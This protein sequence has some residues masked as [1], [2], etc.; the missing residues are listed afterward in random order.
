M[1]G[2][3]VSVPLSKVSKQSTTKLKFGD[4]GFLELDDFILPR[5][6][7]YSDFFKS[8]HDIPT[9]SVSSTRI[10]DMHFMEYGV[11]KENKIKSPKQKEKQHME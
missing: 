7:D 1:L 2:K 6:H 9:G 10:L 5:E 4:G 8:Y 3:K 11:N